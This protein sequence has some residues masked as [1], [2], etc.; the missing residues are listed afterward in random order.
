MFSKRSLCRTLPNSQQ[1]KNWNSHRASENPLL[2]R[3]EAGPT[4]S[5]QFERL[6]NLDTFE[7][8]IYF[9]MVMQSCWW[10]AHHDGQIKSA[11]GNYLVERRWLANRLEYEMYTHKMKRSCSKWFMWTDLMIRRAHWSSLY[12]RR[13]HANRHVLNQSLDRNCL[14]WSL[15]NVRTIRATSA[16]QTSQSLCNTSSSAYWVSIAERTYV[17]LMIPEINA[18]IHD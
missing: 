2:S 8:K 6:I 15:A 16:S 1:I 17:I 4:L 3:R 10:F 14:K 13:V 5:I 11:N 9:R 7:R 18:Q 12:S